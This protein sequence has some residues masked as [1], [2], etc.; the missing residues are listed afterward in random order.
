MPM[1]LSNYHPQWK[2]ISR[3]IRDQADN[4]CEFCGA[5]NGEIIVR[6]KDGWFRVSGTG[7]SELLDGER[8]VRI[9]LTVAHLDH[10]R[11]NNDP[12]NLRALCQRCHLR[13]DADLHAKSAAITR[14]N[15]R[16]ERGQ[17]ELVPA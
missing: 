13:W 7:E 17:I 15:R 3:Q 14:R 6:E 12:M 11:S 5:P 8:P 16:V 1:N 4:R 9:V 2:S 10:D